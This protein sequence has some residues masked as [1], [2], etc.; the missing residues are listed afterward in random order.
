MKKYTLPSP[1]EFFLNI[2]FY[3]QFHFSQENKSDLKS[4]QY[5][6]D[7]CDMFCIDCGKE[8]I[9]ENSEDPFNYH[10]I[11]NFDHVL[12]PGQFEV[13]LICNRCC[14]VIKALK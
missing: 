6:D 7:K 2:P 8:S 9:F 3:K 14:F 4:L 10:S 5:Y 11:N 1:E 12:S 13:E